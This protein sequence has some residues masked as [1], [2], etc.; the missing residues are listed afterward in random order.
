MSD[1]TDDFLSFEKALREL[2]MR[3]EELKKLVSEGEIRAFRDGDSMKFRRDDVQAL[4]SKAAGDAELSFAD[5]LEDDT[6]M[7]TEQ[8]SD[9]DTLL[10]DDDVVIEATP[11]RRASPARSG[12]ASSSADAGPSKE[13]GWVTAVAILGALVMVYGMIVC[14]GISQETDPATDAMMGWF[15][16]K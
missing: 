6:G 12:R 13:P 11:A 10:A 4:T 9:E 7:V 8:I 16:S 3:S 14:Y 1:K 2:K 5:S 15:A